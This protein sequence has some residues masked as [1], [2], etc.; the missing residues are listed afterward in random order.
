MYDGIPVGDG[1]DEHLDPRQAWVMINQYGSL[2]IYVNW[3]D[4]DASYQG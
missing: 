2:E 4:W 1:L 3:W